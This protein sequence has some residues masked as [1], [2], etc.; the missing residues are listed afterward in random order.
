MLPSFGLSRHVTRHVTRSLSP[1][2]REQFHNVFE[3]GRHV[4]GVRVTGALS[5]CNETE[6]VFTEP[7]DVFQLLDKCAGA[8]VD[9]RT[10]RLRGRVGASA[11]ITLGTLGMA[12]RLR[13]SSAR[14]ARARWAASVGP[15]AWLLLSTSWLGSF[16][17]SS[18]QQFNH[19]SLELTVET[20]PAG[21]RCP[22]SC[23]HNYWLHGCTHWRR[24]SGVQLHE[25]SSI[26]WAANNG[27]A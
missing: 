20:S 8:G 14:P 2:R 26:C 22:N 4:E 1:Y 11:R 15:R 21:R 24:G 16:G 6:D 9:A 5:S 18:H 17:T 19:Q 7:L 23:H 25:R 10:A 13:S 12:R 3:D 27:R